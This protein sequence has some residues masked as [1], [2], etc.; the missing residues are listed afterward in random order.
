M[1]GSEPLTRGAAA[2]Y[3]VDATPEFAAASEVFA[4]PKV[5]IRFAET[6]P[7]T[8]RVDVVVTG[9]H[10]DQ[11]GSDTYFPAS[12]IATA[13]LTWVTS[14][15]GKPSK[16]HSPDL[17]TTATHK[18]IGYLNQAPLKPLMTY[19]GTAGG[20]TYD[21]TFTTQDGRATPRTGT[22]SS[23]ELESHSIW[24]LLARSS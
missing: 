5:V 21:I 9:Y 11:R 17:E 20:T 12:Q 7:D 18:L 1:G 14:P 3:P 24:T 10:R 4:E 2:L 22:P 13:K 19:S 23:P 15:F 16:S 6:G 8:T